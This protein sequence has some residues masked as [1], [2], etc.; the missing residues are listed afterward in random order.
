LVM[1]ANLSTQKQTTTIPVGAYPSPIAI[2]PDGTQVWVATLTGLDVVNVTT[3]EVGSIA[4]PGEPSAIVFT[5]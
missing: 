5:Q 2:T 4:L 3:G 1:A